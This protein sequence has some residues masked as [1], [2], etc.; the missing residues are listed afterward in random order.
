MK[1]LNAGEEGSGTSI[2]VQ[3]DG[4]ILVGGYSYIEGKGA[5]ATL[6]RFTRRGRIQRSF[7]TNGMFTV[8]G[9]DRW[10]YVNGMAR[11]SDGSVILAGTIEGGDT[12]D[13]FLYR[14][15]GSDLV[16]L[17]KPSVYIGSRLPLRPIARYLKMQ[18]P[19]GASLSAR[20]LPASSTICKIERGALR[21]L[22]RGRC[23]VR[24]T[25]TRSDDTSVSRRVTLITRRNTG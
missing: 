3:R 19:Q 14:L 24:I 18:L 2:A 16:L 23:M 4:K 13:A 8:G 22:K 6:I 21:G 20:V 1:A 12:D 17:A 9:S 7:G 10:E 11:A 15:K 5:Q 25:V